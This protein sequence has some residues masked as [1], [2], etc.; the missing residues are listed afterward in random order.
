MTDHDTWQRLLASNRNSMECRQAYADWLEQRGDPQAG[1][2][3]N[4][5]IVPALDGEPPYDTHDIWAAVID[6]AMNHIEI[7]PSALGPTRIE[8]MMA[9]FTLAD[10]A[11][12]IAKS[13]GIN[14]D[15]D[16]LCLGQLHN[17]R[18]FFIEAGCSYSGWDTHGTGRLIIGPN[19]ESIVRF[20]P[21]VAQR[22]RLNLPEPS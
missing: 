2:Y 5:N 13:P 17:G 8:A 1:R 12:I 7:V 4:P 20:G 6:A 9:R 22:L 10:I 14:E 16:W 11:T 15:T 3:R 21:G 18:Y 19:F